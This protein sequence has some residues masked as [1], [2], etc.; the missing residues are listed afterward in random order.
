MEYSLNYS[1]AKGSLWFYSKM[2]LLTLIQIL[3][4]LMISN[5]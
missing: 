5:L 2:K 1:E 3:Q 4:T